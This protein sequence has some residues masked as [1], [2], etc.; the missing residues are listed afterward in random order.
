MR[1][2]DVWWSPGLL[3]NHER[4]IRINRSLPTS[5]EGGLGARIAGDPSVSYRPEAVGRSL[6]Y[7]SSDTSSKL[8]G[9]LASQ[10][11]NDSNPASSHS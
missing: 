3:A 2:I 8:P 7:S 9:I 10:V 4:S 5:I 1:A 11:S 6:N